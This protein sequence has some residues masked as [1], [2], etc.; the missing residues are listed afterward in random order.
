MKENIDIKV[1]KS[2]KE[3]LKKIK[4][5]SKNTY[6][7]QIKKILGSSCSAPV[8]KLAE[9]IIASYT[10]LKKERKD[11][12][13]IK[14]IFIHNEELHLRKVHSALLT[15]LPRLEYKEMILLIIHLY[16]EK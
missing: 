8:E 7:E 10:N 1:F 14:S 16:L 6:T 2:D 15:K 9:K 5:K 12:I 13:T 3:L 4:E 11:T